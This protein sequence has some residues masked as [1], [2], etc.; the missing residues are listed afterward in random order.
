MNKGLSVNEESF[1]TIEQILQNYYNDKLLRV[2]EI[3]CQAGSNEG[4]L[5]IEDES[6]L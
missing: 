6:D 2:L 3:S 4:G 5:V 1:N